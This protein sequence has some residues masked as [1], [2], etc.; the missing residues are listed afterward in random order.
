MLRNLPI[1]T[2]LPLFALAAAVAAAT[3]IGILVVQLLNGAI[4]QVSFRKIEAA[5]N[6]SR[7]EIAATKNFL[8]SDLAILARNGAIAQNFFELRN[9]VDYME[10]DRGQAMEFLRDQ[11]HAQGTLGEKER[12]AMLELR[13]TERFSDTVFTDAH[14]RLHPTFVNILEE[15]KYSDIFL[16]NT[17]GQVIYSVRKG[18]D[19]GVDLSSSAWRRSSLAQAVAQVNGVNASKTVG[20]AGFAPYPANDGKNVAFLARQVLDRK[21]GLLGTLVIQISEDVFMPILAQDPGLGANTYSFI[22]DQKIDPKIQHGNATDVMLEG[23]KNTLTGETRGILQNGEVISATYTGNGIKY[24]TSLSAVELFGQQYILGWQVPDGNF[25]HIALPLMQKMLA[26]IAF[27]SL[28]FA[29]AVYLIMRSLLHPLVTLRD[30]LTRITKTLDLG[31]RVGNGNRD[32]IGLSTEAVD[33]IIQMFENFVRAAKSE[34][35][36][37]SDV[38]ASM[39]DQAKKLSAHADAKADSAADLSLSMRGTR[40]HLEET[41]TFATEAAELASR[42]SDIAFDGREKVSQMVSSMNRIS[43]SAKDIEKVIKVIDDIAFQTNILALNAA[44]EAARAGAQGRG[45]GVVAAEV[46]NLAARSAAAAQE[47][48][49]LISDSLERTEAGVRASDESAAAFNSISSDITNIFD[50]VS[51]ISSATEQ[52][53]SNIRV[54]DETAAALSQSAE[55]NTRLSEQIYE[56]AANLSTQSERVHLRMANFILSDAT[57]NDRA[58]ADPQNGITVADGEGFAPRLKRTRLEAA[59]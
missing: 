31:V 47:T 29:G 15:R 18:E 37:L 21:G 2:K 1:A 51:K 42:A 16:V 25:Q 5:V 26:V 41:A 53:A 30:G 24:L 33:E 49:R 7:R 32:E 38:A 4:E 55:Q 43:A 56:N 57:E 11:F 52:N 44:V 23:M 3:L 17:L 50:F 45:F 8:V 27:G 6:S 36:Q 22:A 59:E 48:A 39:K 40:A 28:L 9:A 46:G 54:V 20:F 13:S 14:S 10:R 34:A 35:G 12:I 19:F 58:P